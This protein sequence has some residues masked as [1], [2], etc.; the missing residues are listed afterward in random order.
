MGRCLRLKIAFGNF[1]GE[2]WDEEY[3]EYQVLNIERKLVTM[4]RE[5]FSLILLKAHLVNLHTDL[6]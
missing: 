1:D 3:T 2:F 5:S 4:S 6:V